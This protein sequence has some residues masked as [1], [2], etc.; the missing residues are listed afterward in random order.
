MTIVRD[1]LNYAVDLAVNPAKH[2]L[3]HCGTGLEAYDAWVQA[4][5]DGLG[6]TQGN[7]RNS[8]MAGMRRDG[9]EI[10]RN[11]FRASRGNPGESTG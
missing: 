9:F 5:N 2:R 8:I 1:S 7:L 4:V 6:P 3:E 10:L 11:R